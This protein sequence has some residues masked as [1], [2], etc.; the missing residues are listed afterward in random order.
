MLR[1]TGSPT[2]VD[3]ARE[4]GVSLKTASRV[5]NSS[6]Q[7]SA[8]TEK[9]VRA[10]MTR[11]GYQ[12]NEMARGLKVR[13]SATIGMVV[14]N[15]ADPFTA[16]SIKAVQDVARAHEHVVILASSG[17]DE[18]LEREEVE[19][20]MRRQVDGLI[21]APADGRKN[22]LQSIIPE[23]VPVVTFDQ[24]MRGSSWDCILV[25]NREAAKEATEHLIGHGYKN[26]L[27]IGARPY[28]Y[29]CAERVAGY[30][31]AVTKARLKEQ[32]LLV[33]HEN[34]LTAE[35]LKKA[36]SGPK[37]IQAIFTLNWVTTMLVL[38]ALRDLKKKI[39]KDV[40][41]ISFDDFDLA[42]I[43]TPSLTVV[44]QPPSELGRQA[45]EL[46]FQRMAGNQAKKR[47]TI[48]LP[49]IFEIR[50]SCGCKK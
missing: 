39:V 12:P 20:L 50:E 5:L 31:E 11:L 44:R 27:A 23:R 26:I 30:R 4:A 6:P 28:L 35:I 41:L 18:G 37:P 42:D 7:L 1:K 17:G 45:A 47:K 10:V 48:T 9:R 49:T 34:E 38:H 24:P 2:L 43:L 8:E 22:T 3:V 16:S 46:L 15:L 13:R 19:I 29:T 32:T 25:P 33:D 40:A 14:P 21:L 36:L